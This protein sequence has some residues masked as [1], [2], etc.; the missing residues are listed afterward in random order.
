MALC[1]CYGKRL[2]AGTPTRHRIWS[3]GTYST[4]GSAIDRI[5]CIQRK[6]DALFLC[7]FGIYISFVE[8]V[9]LQLCIS[10]GV[11]RILGNVKMNILGIN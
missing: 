1:L 10:L 2:K 11:T 7:E 6:L 5:S 3:T 4:T 8:A 9:H